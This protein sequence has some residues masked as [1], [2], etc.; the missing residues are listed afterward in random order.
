V[1]VRHKVEL[2]STPVPALASVDSMTPDLPLELLR[3]PVSRTPLRIDGDAL[4]SATG[5]RYAL[6]TSAIPVFAPT[7]S[8]TAQRQQ[9]HYDRIAAAY[10]ANL[11]YPHTR[12]YGEHLDAATV[13]AAGDGLGVCAE[14]CC[15]TAEGFALL[16]SHIRR[17]I[18]IDV[19]LAML[20]RAARRHDDARFSFIQGDA[21]RLP[22][23]D[24]SFDSVVMLGG[25]HHV[26][27]REA[28]FGE[29]ARILKPGGIFLWRE[30]VSDFVLWRALRA[31]VYRL[32]PMLDDE[33]ERP[34]V[35][36]ETVPVLTRAGLTLEDWKTYGFFGFCVFMNSDVLVFNRLFRFV[37]GI[38]AITRAAARF[39]S[40]TISLPG[41]SRAGLQVVGR[42]RKVAR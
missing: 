23:A 13:A 20:E 27:D 35:W 25:V 39:D 42:A 10:S 6:G 41:L 11:D 34:L 36:D 12:A 40:W 32:S 28:L 22:L 8:T 29:I 38:A 18:G 19:S 24:D 37:P 33:T 31:I 2:K 15:G 4:V 16:G 9:D 5:A 1:H 26:P 21:T 7:L 14:L 30:P 3:C 17:G